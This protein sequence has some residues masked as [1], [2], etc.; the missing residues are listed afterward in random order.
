MANARQFLNWAMAVQ[1]ELDLYVKL[2][3][4]ITAPLLLTSADANFVSSWSG[5][6][7][8]FGIGED[9][10]EFLTCHMILSKT[11]KPFVLIYSC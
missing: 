1:E 11:L 5:K 8:S 10:F 4:L 6:S 3:V 9:R 7:L 2:P